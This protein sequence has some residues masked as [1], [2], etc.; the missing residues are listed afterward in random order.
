MKQLIFFVFLQLLCAPAFARNDLNESILAEYLKLQKEYYTNSCTPGTEDQYQKLD[1]NYRG[2]GN[3]IPVLLDEKVDLKTIKNL[4]PL[5]KEKDLWLQAQIDF[6]KKIDD[7]QP[8][9]FE[10]DRL[11]N[12]VELLQDAKKEYYFTSDKSKKESIQLKAAKQFEQLLKEMEQLKKGLPFLLS[13]KFPINHLAL[14]HEYEKFKFTPTKEARARANSIYLFRKIVQDG[15]YDKELTRND[16]VIRSAF[17]TLYLSLTKDKN[18]IFLT[19]N[20]RVDLNFVIKNFAKLLSNKPEVLIERFLEWKARNDRSLTFY[21]DLVENKKIKISESSQIKDVTTLLEERAKSLYTLKDF[22]LTRESKAYEYWSK[23]SELLQSLY[24]IETILYSEVGRMDS[25]DALERRDVAQVVINRS[26]NPTY[27]SLSDKDSITKYL[28]AGQN[29]NDNKWLNVLFKEGEFSFTYFYIP[30]NFHIYCPD[31][32]KVGQFLRRENVRI[33]LE[34]LNKPRANFKALRYFS[35]TSMFGRIEM[36]SLWD[37]F[38]SLPEVPGKAVKAPKKVYQ[39]FKKD[40]YKFLYQFSNEDLKKSYLVVNL[41]GK[42]YVVDADN[43]KQ[44][45]NYRNPHQFKYFTLL[46]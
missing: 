19:D 18:R 8:W 39:L 21:Q 28:P 32:S 4:I 31:M 12:N 10:L 27:N 44:I 30:G 15:S 35:R 43:N 20:E 45:Y 6:I 2:D 37:Q 11:E 33:A 42:T 40:R 34:L 36:D 13:F 24:A 26:V 14:R 23:K 9:R 5:M 29:I 46:K 1:K 16:A 41:L 3:F 22:V 25:P 17:D 7:I 38:E